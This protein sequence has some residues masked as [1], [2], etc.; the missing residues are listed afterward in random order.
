MDDGNHGSY[1][2]AGCLLGAVDACAD[3]CH[4]SVQPKQDEAPG[5]CDGGSDCGICGE[6]DEQRAALGHVHCKA[7]GEKRNACCKVD[8]V[9]ESAWRGQSDAEGAAEGRCSLLTEADGH[10]PEECRHDGEEAL[11][12]GRLCGSDEGDAGL[13]AGKEGGVHCQDE[14]RSLGASAEAIWL[15]GTTA[16]ARGCKSW[17][18]Q[19]RWCRP[20]ARRKMRAQAHA[21]VSDSSLQSQPCYCVSAMDTSKEDSEIVTSS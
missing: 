13:Q 12:T 14:G 6:G 17:V 19:Q 7:H 16:V 5:A 2:G 15:A 1:Q 3:G 11:G 21:R 9:A 20:H 4:H 8:D 18:A 10:L